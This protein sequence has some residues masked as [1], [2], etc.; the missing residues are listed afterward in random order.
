MHFVEDDATTLAAKRAAR[1][2]RPDAARAPR[3]RPRR[4]RRPADRRARPRPR[5]LGHA[6]RARRPDRR[7]GPGR[8]RRPRP[9][10]DGARAADR[11]RARRLAHAR[12]A[13]AAAGDR[14][15]PRR[16][17][18]G[19]W[20]LLLLGCLALAALSLLLPCVPT[21]DPWAWIIWGREVAHLR[22]R[23]PRPGPSWKP[24]PVIF[25]TPFS[26]AGDDGAPLLWL[27]V[28][29][30]GGILAFAMAYRLGARLAGPVAG[31]DR[32][33]LAVPRRRVHPQ[34]RARQL[35]GHPRRALPVGDRA[36]PRRPPPRRVPARPRRRAAAARGVAVHRAL[37]PLPDRRRPARRGDGRAR[38]R[39]RRSGWCVLWFVPEYLGSGDFL[40]AAARA[41][42]P[43][44]DSAA[45][46]AHPF[47]EVFSRSASVLT[48]PVY[49]GG[50]IAVAGR[51]ARSRDAGRPVPRDGRDRHRAD[52]RGGRR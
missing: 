48:P 32:R 5:R 50:V 3:A 14:P 21:Y 19:P 37:R 36:P 4:R 42:Q 26:L 2:R 39:R 17:R 38:A 12:A 45:F 25:T 24:L 10:V 30:A 16:H 18:R 7:A 8:R 40:R 29:R 49:V 15:T 20:K 33:R 6:R 43:N 22:P 44:P 28:A 41:R 13:R 51:A 11:A 34:L 47:I 52:G 35:R 9:A 1:L 27:V 46:A 31:R 23:R